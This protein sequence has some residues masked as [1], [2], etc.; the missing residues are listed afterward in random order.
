MSAVGTN[1]RASVHKD[2]AEEVSF[3]T[4]CAHIYIAYEKAERIYRPYRWSIHTFRCT[5]CGIEAV[6]VDRER[7]KARTRP[8]ASEG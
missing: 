6:V 3:M 8:S 1:V 5:S 2:V 7:I 4:Q